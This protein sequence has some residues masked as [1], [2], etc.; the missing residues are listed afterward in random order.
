MLNPESRSTPLIRLSFARLAACTDTASSESIND[1][2]ITWATGLLHRMA[3]A[4]TQ[5]G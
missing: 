2:I 4:C 1:D 3:S 5:S